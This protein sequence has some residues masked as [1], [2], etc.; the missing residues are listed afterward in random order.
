MDKEEWF[1]TQMTGQL[2]YQFYLELLQLAAEHSVRALFCCMDEH[3]AEKSKKTDH[4]TFVT[5]LLLERI[6]Q[7]LADTEEAFVVFAEPSGGD[8]DQ[9]TFLSDCFNSLQSGTSVVQFKRIALTVLTSPFR[10]LRLLQLADVVASC[11]MARVC[12]ENTYSP[13]IFSQILPLIPTQAHDRRG[14]A[15]F[16]ILPIEYSNLYFTLLGDKHCTING[17]TEYRKLPHDDWP[18]SNGK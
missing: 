17:A 15:S 6:E 13:P 12:G 11:S 18:Y 8:T 14:G 10:L 1:R 3:I 16:K 7:T 9:R 4:E 5:K 2:R